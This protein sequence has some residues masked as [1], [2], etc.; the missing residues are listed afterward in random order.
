VVLNEFD[1]QD[2]LRLRRPLP[3]AYVHALEAH[4]TLTRVISGPN[5]P[6]GMVDGLPERDLPPDMMY[7]NP[8]IL[9]YTRK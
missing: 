6:N 2:R 3:V 5:R 8:I 1:Y 9:I 7:T 4:Y